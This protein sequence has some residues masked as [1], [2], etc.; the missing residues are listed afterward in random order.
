MENLKGIYKLN[1]DLR[2]HGSLEGTFI[3]EKEHV[4]VLIESKIEVYFG[5]VLGKHSDISGS[6]EDVDL[7]LVSDSPEAIKI[8]EELGLQTG[9]NPFEYTTI[10]DTDGLT[11]LDVVKKIIEQNRKDN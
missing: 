4:K 1:I 5:E 6:I 7:K 11:V 2:R 8:V 10:N 9:Y 3:A